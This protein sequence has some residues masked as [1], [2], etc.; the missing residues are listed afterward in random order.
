[1]PSA[2]AHFGSI[3]DTRAAASHILEDRIEKEDHSW[4]HVLSYLLTARNPR[5]GK[6]P[7][8]EEVAEAYVLISVGEP[9]L[10]TH[11]FTLW[12]PNLTNLT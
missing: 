6:K 11:N 1:M 8:F 9:L 7:T 12:T 3:R 4:N 10:A 5:R 2:Q